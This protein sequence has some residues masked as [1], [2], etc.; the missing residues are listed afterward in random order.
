M[1]WRDAFNVAIL[2]AGA[3]GGWALRTIWDAVSNLRD[4]VSELER[5]LPE[6]YARRDD[7]KDLVSTLV[8]RFDR[9]EEKVDRLGAR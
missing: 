2:I 7:M 5:S 4:T 8:A 1:D 6:T 9:L 3:I